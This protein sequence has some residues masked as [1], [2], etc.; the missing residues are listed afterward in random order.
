VLVAHGLLLWAWREHLALDLSPI[1]RLEVDLVQQ[2]RLVAPRPVPAKPPV[3]AQARRLSPGALASLESRAAALPELEPLLLKARQAV[4]AHQASYSRFLDE[5]MARTAEKLAPAERIRFDRFERGNTLA[6]ELA[7]D[8]GVQRI[9]AFSGGLWA[10]SEQGGRVR[11]SDLRMG[12]E[13]TY[14]FA[15]E[16]ATRQSAPVAVTPTV[17]VGR[18]ADPGR[19][20]PWI[21]RRLQG[22]PLPPPR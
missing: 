10:M 2:M 20:L 1:P 12:Q 17:H 18:R 15:F 7:G 3:T 4:A 21:W 19:A 6:A 13:P 16:V 9:Q 22:E 8:T 5:Q 14:I 11:I